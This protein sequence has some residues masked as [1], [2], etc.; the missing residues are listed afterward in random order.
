[1]HTHSVAPERWKTMFDS[2]SRI[3]E[4]SIASLEVLS[5]ELGDQF[6]VEEEPFRGIS[7]DRSGIELIFTTR[8]GQ[9]LTHI[10]TKPKRVLLEENDDGLI[11][12]ML[13]E[14]EDQPTIVL[15][16]HSPIASKLLPSGEE[17]RGARKPNAK[18]DESRPRG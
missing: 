8:D 6:E 14:S 18:R 17:D 12:A 16:L 3:Y 9:H 1:M 10:V 11:G 13:I 4:G 15:R 2:L 7:A 5:P